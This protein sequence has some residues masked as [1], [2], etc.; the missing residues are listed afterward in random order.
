MLWETHM[1]TKTGD[2]AAANMDR[3]DFLK[4]CGVLGAGA[5]IAPW[6]A[7]A[8]SGAAGRPN[9]ILIMTDVDAPERNPEWRGVISGDWELLVKHGEAMPGEDL[10]LFNL[11]KDPK[12]QENLA[13]I[14]PDRVCEL[15]KA[16][17]SWWNPESTSRN[18]TTTA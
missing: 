13:A 3:R 2:R 1:T 5:M 14:E 11:K 7:A 8:E 4:T 12:E 15:Q 10:F 16:L 17:D 9:V 6:G 18:R